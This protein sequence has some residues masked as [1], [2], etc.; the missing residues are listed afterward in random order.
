MSLS[1]SGPAAAQVVTNPAQVRSGTYG[2]E[3]GHTQVTFT[4]LHLGFTNYLGIFSN[5][6]GTLEL[7]A[8]T[9]SRSKLSVT[10][11]VASVQTTSSRLTEELKGEQ[12]F[13]AAR[14]PAATFVSTTVRLTGQNEALVTGNLTLHGVTKAETLKVHFIGAGINAMD[15]KYTTG[16]EATAMIRR[17]DFGVKMYVPYV[18]DDV[19]LRIAG[20]FEQQD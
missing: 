9:P 10:I 14:F 20:A 7:D 4:V 5:A 15:K 17:S 3:P 19:Q 18:S 6:S 1:S 16:F 11:P 12:W 2:V 13:D 8:R